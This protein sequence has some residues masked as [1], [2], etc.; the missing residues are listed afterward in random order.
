MHQLLTSL[1]GARDHLQRVAR[2]MAGNHA[3]ADDLVQET[4]RRALEAAARFEPGSNLMAWL[5]CI[6]RNLHRDHVRH[7]ARHVRLPAVEEVPARGV[8]EAALW[9]RIGDDEVAAALEHMPPAF[10]QVYLAHARGASYAAIGRNLGLTVGTVSSR[11]HR[12]RR[13]LRGYL[14]RGV[15]SAN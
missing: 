4:Y 10:R 1:P 11:M 7:T 15:A 2:A 5:I 9:R 12:G 6:L 3:D 14:V 8:E 13:W